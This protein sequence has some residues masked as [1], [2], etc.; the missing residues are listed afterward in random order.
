MRLRTV[1]FSLP[2]CLLPAFAH[3][4]CDIQTSTY[5]TL[6]T[7]AAPQD[8]GNGTY[9]VIETTIIEGSA[10][11][12]MNPSCPCTNCITQF[13]N[14]KQYITHFPYITNTINGVGGRTPGPTFCAEC[15]SSYQVSTDSGALNPGQII[16]AMI[17]GEIDCSTAGQI[18]YS[19]LP[20]LQ[21]EI[22]YTRAKG[23][24]TYS[25][26]TGIA[27]V[28]CDYDT[29]SDCTDATSP[30]DMQ[31]GKVRASF[32]E[33]PPLIWECFGLGFRWYPYQSNWVF[34]NATTYAYKSGIDLPAP[35][36]RNP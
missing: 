35:C 3:G 33:A 9:D 12:N 29:F 19:L 18:F 34:T 27:S 36:T 30:P 8:N 14:N 25:G 6:S 31:I 2:F 4:Q 1:L 32:P 21:L 26:C 22:A 11:M 16:Y 24:G 7:S 15:F 10:T 28:V 23:L 17:G 5:Y 20:T 13:N